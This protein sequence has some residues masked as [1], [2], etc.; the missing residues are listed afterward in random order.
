ME[1]KIQNEKLKKKCDQAEKNE[2]NLL[3]EKS[4]VEK[5]FNS[6]QDDIIQSKQVIA[7]ILNLI[8]EHGSEELVTMATDCIA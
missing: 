3:I 8:H 2:K 5:R 7:T 4:Q 1:Y 6:M